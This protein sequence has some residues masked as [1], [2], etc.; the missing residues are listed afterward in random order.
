METSPDTCSLGEIGEIQIQVSAQQSYPE[1][2][3][4]PSDTNTAH[5]CNGIHGDM[6][7]VHPQ[8]ESTYYY[9]NGHFTQNHYDYGH[10]FGDVRTVSSGASPV[11]GFNHENPHQIVQN[12]P[13]SLQFPFIRSAANVRERKRMLSINSAFEELR[14]HVPTFPFEKRLSK[15]DTLRLAIAYIELLKDILLSGTDPLEH[16]E[17]T[18]AEIRST[19][20]EDLV[21]WNTSGKLI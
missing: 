11:E 2:E 4:T 10:T 7:D 5:Y 14:N 19:K 15:I 3:I 1:P 9:T 16:I 8:A 13:Q 21:L 20:N 18:L 12:N 17:E 6:S